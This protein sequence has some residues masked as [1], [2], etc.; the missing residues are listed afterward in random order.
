MNFTQ[1]L[2]DV[3]NVDLDIDLEVPQIIWLLHV[4]EG[5]L[6]RECKGLTGD[7]YGEGDREYNMGCSLTISE[8]LESELLESK[9][10]ESE[11]L[12][13]RLILRR[14]LR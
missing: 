10:L 11:L 4:G 5:D 14:L 12:D 9:L 1:K 7:L 2:G 13:D 6:S 8:L 3:Y